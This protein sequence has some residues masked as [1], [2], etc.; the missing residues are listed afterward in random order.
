ML[1]FSTMKLFSAR[2]VRTTF[3]FLQLMRYDSFNIWDIWEKSILTRL[4]TNAYIS[5]I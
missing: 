4:C 3:L 2:R 1:Q 5:N